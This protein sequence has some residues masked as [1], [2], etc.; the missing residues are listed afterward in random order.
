[1]VSSG[2]SAESIVRMLLQG[3]EVVVKITGSAIKNVAVALYA[4]SKEKGNSKGKV[5]LTKMLNT[6]K[7]CKIYSIKEEDLKV[8]KKQA[9]IYG[10]LFCALVNKNEKSKDGMVDLMIR[11]EDASKVNRIVSRFNLSSID[12]ATLRTEN[13]KDINLNAKI[14]TKTTTKTKTKIIEDKEK[15]E[16]DPKSMGEKLKNQSEN[17]SNTKNQQMDIKDEKTSVKEKIDGFKDKIKS[18]EEEKS[19]ARDVRGKKPEKT[20]KKNRKKE[21]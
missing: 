5:N 12:R 3:T 21:R 1:M 20:K 15:R 13:E 18:K 19:K 2:D 8:F 4:L 7:E 16:V 6:K 9:N 10:V 14:E 11:S 17:L